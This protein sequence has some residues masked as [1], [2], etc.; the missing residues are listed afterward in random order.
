MKSLKVK[1]EPKK[2]TLMIKKIIKL[3][4]KIKKII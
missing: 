2:S 1:K 3:Y 4:K